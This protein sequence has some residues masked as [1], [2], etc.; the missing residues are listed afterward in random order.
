MFG[1]FCFRFLLG[2]WLWVL[3]FFF[4]ICLFYDEAGQPINLCNT[5]SSSNNIILLQLCLNAPSTISLH[6]LL[7]PRVKGEHQGHFFTLPG[8]KWQQANWVSTGNEKDFFAVIS[9]WAPRVHV[10]C[11]ADV[12]PSQLCILT[13]I[14]LSLC[15]H[16]ESA[17]PSTHPATSAT[18]FSPEKK[19][20][21]FWPYHSTQT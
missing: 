21:R 14:F 18:F 11:T 20:Y 16:P 12:Q 1:W 17:F 5:Q 4:F 9:S 8:S 19:D 10:E 2:F 3:F 6:Y 7:L 15:P 13:S